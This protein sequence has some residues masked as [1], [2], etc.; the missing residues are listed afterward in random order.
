MANGADTQTRGE[1]IRAFAFLA[2]ILVPVLAV[3]FVAGYGFS[4]WIFQMIAGPPGPP[5]P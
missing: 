3:L 2:L 1:E 5:P 4:V